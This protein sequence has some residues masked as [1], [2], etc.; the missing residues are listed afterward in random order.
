M[1][2]QQKSLLIHTNYLSYCF[3]YLYR[4]IGLMG[5][6]RLVMTPSLKACG[7]GLFKRFCTKMVRKQCKNQCA[8][9]VLANSLA[10]RLYV[11]G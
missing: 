7:D 6:N 5:Q 4:I 3:L 10:K 1:R 8:K 2:I 11:E 9:L